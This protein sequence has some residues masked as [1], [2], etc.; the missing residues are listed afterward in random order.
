MKYIARLILLSLVAFAFTSCRKAEEEEPL[1]PSR[2]L[3]VYMVAENSLLTFSNTDIRE[4]LS[5]K[6]TLASNQE[7]LLFIDNNKTPAIYRITN[8]TVG[9]YLENLTPEY[10]CSEDFN[11]CTEEALTNFLSY[12]RKNTNSDSYGLLMWSHGTGW[13]PSIYYLDDRKFARRKA[14]GLDNGK[15]SS[16]DIGYSMSITALHKGLQS[17][18]ARFDYLMFDCCFMQTVEMAYELRDVTKYIIGSPA[19]IPGP[20]ANYT[21][22]MPALFGANYSQQIPEKYHNTYSNSQ[23]GSLMSTVDC[24]ALEQLAFATRKVVQA[25]KQEILDMSYDNVLDYFIYDKWRH[26]CTQS[27]AYDMNGIFKTVLPA[28]EYEEWKVSLDKA[29]PYRYST[30]KWYSYISERAN[31]GKYVYSDLEQYYGLSM[32]VP[33]AKY[34]EGEY[35]SSNKFFV[36]AY[37]ESQWAKAVWY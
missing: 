1:E 26:K 21:A 18:G 16:S 34:E 11:S 25:H 14:F 6:S 3:L 31:C 23:Y 35:A 7:I 20:G 10:T 15:N 27:D 8:Q 5:A 33:L 29:I 2:T 28:N 32:Y 9:D 19:E 13:Q 17:W 12:A 36:D 24:D 30:E 4:M 22:L 37:S